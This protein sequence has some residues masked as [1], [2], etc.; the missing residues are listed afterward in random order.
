MKFGKILRPVAAVLSAAV[1]GITSTGCSVEFGTNPKIKDS[2]IVAKPTLETADKSMNVTYEEF[3]KQYTYILK[4]YEIEDDTA[5]DIAE[6]CAEQRE[7]IANNLATNKIIL[8]K[9]K[10]YGVAE[11]T[12][13]EKAEAKKSFET[14]IEQ[15]VEYYSTLA[16]YSDLTEDQITDE[17]KKQRGNEEFDKFLAECG[18]TRDD[19]LLWS[20]EYII[21]TKVLDEAVKHITIDD[22][23]AECDKMIAKVKEMYETD[24]A[25]YEQ[26]G[27]SELWV[28]DGSRLIKHVLLGFDETLQMEL[29]IYRNSGDDEKAD[30]LRKQTADGMAE[31]IAEVQQKL[32]EMNEGKITF[33]E[34]LLNYSADA[35]GSSM[36]PDGYIVVPNG[37]SYMKEFQEAAFVPEKIGDRTVCVTDYGVHIMIYAGDA[38]VSQETIDGFT[39]TAYGEMRNEAFQTTLEQWKAEYNYQLDRELLRLD[40]TTESETSGDTTSTDNTSNAS[41]ESVVS[42]PSQPQN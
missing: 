12:E 14:Q 38:K 6:A 15:Q 31:K 8:Q 7:L 36:Y 9:A 20:E 16:D 17:I 11:L 22:A 32:D 21:S 1:I 35:A 27:Y 23:K 4:L 19:L 39:E 10:E 42:G 30:A 24:I 25:S 2:A 3:N 18:M 41:D 37:V 5:A 33:N 26:G 28:P 29:A 40:I 34:I 13:E